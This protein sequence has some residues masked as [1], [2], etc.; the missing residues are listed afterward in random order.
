MV[1]FN[2]ERAHRRHAKRTDNN[3]I[4]NLS[5]SETSSVLFSKRLQLYGHANLQQ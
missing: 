4:D 5:L 2:D 1:L 3:K